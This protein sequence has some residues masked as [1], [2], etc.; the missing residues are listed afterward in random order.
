MITESKIYFTFIFRSTN[1]EQFADYQK[2]LMEES[3][4]SKTYELVQLVLL[5]TLILAY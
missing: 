1:D 3:Q 2:N 4:K 5:V